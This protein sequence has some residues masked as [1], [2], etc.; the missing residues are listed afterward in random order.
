MRRWVNH[1]YAQAKI[2]PLGIMVDVR[3][4]IDQSDGEIRIAELVLSNNKTA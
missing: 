2:F 3:I 4:I 1:S